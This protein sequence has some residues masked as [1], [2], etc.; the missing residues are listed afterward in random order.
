MRIIMSFVMSMLPYMLFAIPL[1]IIARCI[2]L[3]IRRIQ[4]NWYRE[5]VM[6]LFAIFLVGLASQTIVPGIVSNGVHSTNFV[7]FRMVTEIYSEV[8]LKGNISY[9]LINIFGNIIMFIPIGF[10]IPLL[11]RASAR[12]TLIIGALISL[13]IE[14]CQLFML[15]GTDVDDLLLNTAGV[16][17]GVLLSGIVKKH[18][19]KLAEKLSAKD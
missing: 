7:P 13:T 3:K 6:L 12:R 18:C 4:T 5:T 8:F 10:T 16:F 15:R 9:L 11:W 2:L 14:L 1:Y 17:L 19:C